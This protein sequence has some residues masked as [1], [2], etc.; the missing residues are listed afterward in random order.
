MRVS[1]QFGVGS[2]LGLRDERSIL[3]KQ[4]GT[5]KRALFATALLG[6]ALALSGASAQ[7]TRADFGR[8]EYNTNCRVCHGQTGK[9]DGSYGDLLTTRVPDLT[10]LS[11]R[12]GGVFPFDK[13][14]RTIDG[15]EMPRAHGT[16]EMPIWGAA[17]TNKGAQYFH[18]NAY[19]SEAYV[20]ARLLAL[21]EYVYTMQAR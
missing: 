2:M 8:D 14:V 5:M 20:Q 4:G 7:V 1:N 15:R 17:Y 19:N 16:S 6:A 12:S 18:G 3:I 11:K 9:G 21:T 13:I 10:T